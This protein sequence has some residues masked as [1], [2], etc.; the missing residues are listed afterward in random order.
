MLIEFSVRHFKS[1]SAE[2]SLSME[3]D[4]GTTHLD[5]TFQHHDTRLLKTAVIYGPNASGKTNVIAAFY[6]FRH[7]ILN[8]TDLKKDDPI[9]SYKPFKLDKSFRTQPTCFKITFFGDDNIKYDYEIVFN[10]KQVFTEM[11]NYYIIPIL[12]KSMSLPESIPNL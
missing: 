12:K 5:N 4:S 1:I 11:L 10:K 6:E 7:L 8:S 3:A 9:D 2:Q